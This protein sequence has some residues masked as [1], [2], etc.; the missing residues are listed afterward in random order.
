MRGGQRGARMAEE[1]SE[2]SWGE[3]EQVGPYC[4]EEQVPQDTHSQGELYRAIHETSG[5]MA[6]VLK[7]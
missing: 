3:P 5:A 7:P 1:K 4:V 2:A 6:L